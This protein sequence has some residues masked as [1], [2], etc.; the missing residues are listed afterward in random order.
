M[1]SIALVAVVLGSTDQEIENKNN[2]ELA[3][4]QQLQPI[5]L[6]G[7]HHEL[8]REKRCGNGNGNGANRARR[9]RRA[10]A[11]RAR[12]ARARQ[13]QASN[14]VQSG[15]TQPQQQQQAAQMVSTTIHGVSGAQPLQIV[16]HNSA[17]PP[18]IIIQQHGQQ[19]HQQQQQQQLHFNPMAA[20]YPTAPTGQQMA[21]AAS[22]IAS[23]IRQHV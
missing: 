16:H 6:E 18:V 20:M 5:I 13:A 9:A 21:A 4:P 14:N 19:P 11:A 12:A 1:I 7:H 10:R 8:S 17:S 22:T 23:T 2:N 15:G 3:Q